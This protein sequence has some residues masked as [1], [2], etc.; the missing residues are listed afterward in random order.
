MNEQEEQKLLLQIIKAWRLSEQ[1][2]YRGF[3]CGNCQQYKNQAW[4][5]WL[6]SGNYKLP[7]HLCDDKC[8]QLFQSEQIKIDQ[9]K[10]TGVDRN[11]F[12]KKY[13]YNRRAIERFRKIVTAWSK[14]K[15]PELKAFFCD[16][17]G[18][19]L[20]IDPVDGQRKG[21]H[22]WWKIPNRKTLTELHLHKECAN[23]L[24]IE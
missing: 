9:A 20:E 10:R 2:E 5:H 22:V 24:G 18:R 4:Y 16:E 15:E 11:S 6:N 14:H 19:D 21:F 8:E 3:R 23:R 1:P 12:G 7:V 17:C 13:K